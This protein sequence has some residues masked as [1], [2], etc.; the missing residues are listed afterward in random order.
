MAYD[1]DQKNYLVSII[2]VNYR[3]YGFLRRCL[4]SLKYTHKDIEIIVVDN[5]SNESALE[6]IRRDF[7]DVKLFGLK[8]NLNYA[9]GN[10]FGILRSSGKYVVILN[11]DTIVEKN[12]LDPLIEAGS[13]NSEAFYQPKILFLEKPDT[14]NSFGNTVHLFGFA[15]PIGIG[16]YVSE[17]MKSSERLPKIFYCSGAC[18]FTS[19]QVLDKWEDLIQIIGHIMRM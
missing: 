15:F 12:W 10:N 19:R 14:V 9:E 8:E 7:E 13:A 5:E 18:I 6:G 17:M 11:N 3:E 2:I 4:T 1:M 16:K